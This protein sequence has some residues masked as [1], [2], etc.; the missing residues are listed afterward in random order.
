MSWGDGQSDA[1][2]AANGGIV[3]N[4]DGSFSVVG[5]HTYAEEGA[6]LIFAVQVADANGASASSSTTVDVADPAVVATGGMALAATPGTPLSGAVAAT[7]VDPGGAEPNAA[8]P[9]GIHYTADINWGDGTAS[10]GTIAF[11][12]ATAVFKVLGDHAYA[13]AGTYSITVTVHHELAPDATATSTATITAPAPT[14]SGPVCIGQGPRDLNTLIVT[15]TAGNDVIRVVHSGDYGDVRVII[16]GVSQGVFAKSRFASIAVYGL[17]GNDYLQVDDDVKSADY[18]FGGAGNDMLLGGDGQG[19]LDGGAGNDTLI[20]GEA[21]NVL[22]GGSGA[23]LLVA[24]DARALLIAGAADFQD[25]AVG[26]YSQ[27]IADLMHAWNAP[28]MTYAARAAAVDAVVA[29]HIA[30]D[31]N[32]DVLVGSDGADLYYKSAGD[33]LLGKAKREI[34]VTI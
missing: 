24:R 8:D 11:D 15:G 13:A 18:L 34:A 22:L 16:N 7:F 32:I 25:P 17:A 21:R 33:L 28:D 30:D 20:S 9:N 2:N 23:D 27:A 29:G 1:F 5:S 26:A 12:S 10:A 14:P 4:A 3:A 6:G 31:H 19:W